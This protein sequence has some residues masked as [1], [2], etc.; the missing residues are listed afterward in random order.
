[1]KPVFHPALVNDV[2]GDP[3]VYVDFLFEKRALLFDLGDLRN[4]AT[5]KI[6]RL[7]DVF[8]S[9]AHMDHFFGFDWLLRLCLGREIRI[10]LFGPAGFLAQVEAKLA[11]YTW[12]L[13]ENYDTDFTL[14]V[15]E[16]L[17]EAEAYSARF[18]CRAGFRRENERSLVLRDGV[19]L[20]DE[21]FTV[22]F[23]L[24][25]HKIPCLAFALQEKQHVNIWKNRLD[26]LDLEPGPW[27]QV[28][29]RAVLDRLPGDTLITALQRD[30][31][32]RRNV[33]YRLDDLA[34]TIAQIS[35]G[36]KIAYVTDAVYHDAN[37]ER[38]VQLAHGADQF[39]IE[40]VFGDELVERAAQ[41]YHLTARQAGSLAHRAGVKFAVPFHF[42]PIYH[43][44]E[45]ELREEFERA[46]RGYPYRTWRSKRASP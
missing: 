3:A 13:V 10:R 11:G 14:D 22:R 25:D 19:L 18:R 15:I 28:F 23:G 4:L 35:T 40:A 16:I 8:V 36:Q 33:S 31:Q 24:L 42:S 34:G 30:D 20:D 44:R 2:F 43:D 7:R 29:K 39:F 32:G 1:M 9:H 45:D 37:A 21:N 6:L 5:R 26:E 17:S 46:F 41:K 12:N 38:I 27:L